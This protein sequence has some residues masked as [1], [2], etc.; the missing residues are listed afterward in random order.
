MLERCAI[1][2][3][4]KEPMQVYLNFLSVPEFPSTSCIVIFV[5]HEPIG[6]PIRYQFDAGEIWDASGECESNILQ[7]AFIRYE[8]RIQ[9]SNF[10]FSY[11]D[12]PRC[13]FPSISVQHMGKIIIIN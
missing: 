7:I 1:V 11:T 10:S 12:W 6:M 4:V 3:A 2:T 5:C 9:K 8:T 13:S